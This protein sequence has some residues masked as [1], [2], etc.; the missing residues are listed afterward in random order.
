MLKITLDTASPTFTQ[1]LN[2]GD[3]YLVYAESTNLD[4]GTLTIDRGDEVFKAFDNGVMTDA[5]EPIEFAFD[6]AAGKI[7]FTLAGHG[8]SGVATIYLT[9]TYLT[10][11]TH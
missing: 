4:S 5:A 2:H 6:V 3:T 7:R 1:R 9:R 10:R 11:E 8:A